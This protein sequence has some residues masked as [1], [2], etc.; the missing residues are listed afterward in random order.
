MQGE[1]LAA[2]TLRWRV[3]LAGQFMFVFA[4][5]V[6]SGPGR[7]DINDG[8]TRYEVARSLLEHGDSV[9]R[10]KLVW[11]AVMKGRDGEQYT[12]YRFP[13]TGLGMVAICLADATGPTDESR[14]QFFFTLISPLLCAFLALT[15]AVWFRALGHGPGASL[16]WATAGVFCTPSWYYGT[17][18][19]DDMLGTAAVVP[20]VA[21]A[22][23]ARDRRP[24]L[25]AA[26][27]GLLLGWAFN[28]KQP[29]GVFVLPVLAACY[30]PGVALRRQLVP[31]GLVLAGLALGVAAHKGYEWYKFP[32]GQCDPDSMAEEMYGKVWVADPLPGLSGLTISPS[33]GAL[34]YCPTLLLSFAGWLAWRRQLPGFCKALAAASLLFTLFLSFLTFFKGEPC[35]GPRYLTPM[36]ALWW[37]FVPT[38]AAAMRRSF[39]VLLLGLG[40]L[41]QLLAL[42][43]DPQRLLLAKAIPFNYYQYDRHLHFH[44][45]LSHLLQ[46]PREIRDI[47]GRQRRAPYYTTAPYA[48][49][50]TKVP[51]VYPVVL[52][53]AL[54]HGTLPMPLRPLTMTTAFQQS[55]M[56]GP[57][58]YLEAVERYHVFA[59]F[60]PWWLSQLYL[61]PEERPVDMARTLLLLLAVGSLG[62]G[63]MV[64]AGRAGS[65]RRGSQDR[66]SAALFCE[67]RLNER[68][69]LGRVPA[70]ANRSASPAPPQPGGT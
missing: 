20:A 27:A 69:I 5:V 52:T 40:V 22:F 53:S 1:S 66:A 41:V 50:A 64:V 13:Q 55:T 46:R 67:P 38:A 14:R 33:S 24:V 8:Q 45:E 34:W 35:W 70:A 2:G 49:Y 61:T 30:R 17:S 58:Q 29:L 44:P 25:G 37:I 16:A 54:G 18:T 7:I 6:L 56:H 36:F 11:F 12:N 15:Y 39:V 19:F 63:L 51:S 31:L 42:S 9:I 68:G 23:L 10:D 57:V 48:T 60:R 21:V 43:V 59:S 26:V 4:V 3:A 62:L 65:F 32:P 28:C 47:L